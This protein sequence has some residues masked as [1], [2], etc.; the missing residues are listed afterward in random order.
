VINKL[1]KSGKLQVTKGKMAKKKVQRGTQG[2][3]K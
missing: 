1:M 2:N 3:N